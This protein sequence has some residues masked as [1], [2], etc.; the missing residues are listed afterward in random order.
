MSL[1]NGQ[2]MEQKEIVMVIEGS[3]HDTIL[4]MGLEEVLEQRDGGIGERNKPIDQCK[5]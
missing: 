4:D 3:V 5:D 1:V 2:S